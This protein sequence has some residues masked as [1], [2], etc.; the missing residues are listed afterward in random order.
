MKLGRIADERETPTALRA[1][2]CTLGYEGVPA[3]VAVGWVLLN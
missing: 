1:A 3:T 2:G